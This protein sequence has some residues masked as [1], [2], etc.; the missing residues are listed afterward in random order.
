MPLYQSLS[1]L[2]PLSFPRLEKER[3]KRKCIER[4][5]G[6]TKREPTIPFNLSF[7]FFFLA[8]FF[9]HRLCR[10]RHRRRRRRRRP[11]RPLSRRLILSFCC[12]PAFR[13]GFCAVVV[14]SLCSRKRREEPRI[15][16]QQ[17][18]QI[19]PRHFH[20]K[21]S[22]LNR[23]TET[24]FRQENRLANLINQKGHNR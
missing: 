19:F 13:I 2:F 3:E 18:R 16:K 24:I 4:E 23:M 15:S 11:H 9:F 1:I 17:K 8:C 6:R 21:F 20:R 22:A 5:S 10:R 7:F 14:S 12:S